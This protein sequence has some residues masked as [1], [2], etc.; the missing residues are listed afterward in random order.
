[1]PKFSDLK[2]YLERN[3]WEQ[4]SRGGKRN[5]HLYF[6]KVLPN[7]QILETRVSHSLSK[8]IPPHRFKEILKRQLEITEQEFNDNK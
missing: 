4:F 8:E 6:R 1:M 3:G 2:R 7:G 5:H